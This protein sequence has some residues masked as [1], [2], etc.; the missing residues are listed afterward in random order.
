[1]IPL[2]LFISIKEHIQQTSSI[3]WLAKRISE[4]EDHV[5]CEQFKSFYILKLIEE[6]EEE[7]KDGATSWCVTIKRGKT[8]KMRI[9]KMR[10]KNMISFLIIIFILFPFSSSSSPPPFKSLVLLVHVTLQIVDLNLHMFKSNKL[11]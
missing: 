7:E 3:N 6:D 5:C 10:M 1:M 2:S 8:G 9:K 4:R 11:G